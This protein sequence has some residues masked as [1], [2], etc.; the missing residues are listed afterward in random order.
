MQPIPPIAWSGRGGQATPPQIERIAQQ[1]TA[2][3]GEMNADLM[4]T[5]CGDRHLKPVT[6]LASLQQGQLRVGI[7]SPSHGGRVAPSVIG[8]LWSPDPTQ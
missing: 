8:R 7:A 2:Q 4:G 6:L 3:L 5:T 1:R